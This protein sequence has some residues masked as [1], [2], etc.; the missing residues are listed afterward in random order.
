MLTLHVCTVSLRPRITSIHLGLLLPLVGCGLL[1]SLC[2]RF[3]T[4][5]SCARKTDNSIVACKP[6]LSHM[7]MHA[8]TERQGGRER[9]REIQRDTCLHT[10]SP[11]FHLFGC[12][13]HL[14][15]LS[16]GLFPSLLGC[17]LLGCSLL[18][19]LLS[20]GLLSLCHQFYTSGSC[21]RKTD[22]SIRE[23]GSV[24]YLGMAT[25]ILNL[26]LCIT[27][28]MAKEATNPKPSIQ[29]E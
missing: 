18:L 20:C 16:C 12:G 26:P 8:Y 17:A 21:G 11:R 3:Y 29:R 7:Y 24:L 22:N 27:G 14:S 25:E 15:L 19:S 2:H 4:S 28:I 9:E 5:G 1:L 13:L 10:L 6:T 23:R